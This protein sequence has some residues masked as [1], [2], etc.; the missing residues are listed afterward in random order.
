MD[1]QLTQAS[2]QLRRL[3]NG[4]QVS[5][6][7]SVVARLGIADLMAGGRTSVTELASA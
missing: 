6:A 5:Q 7:I 3:V 2:V 4:Y 1:E